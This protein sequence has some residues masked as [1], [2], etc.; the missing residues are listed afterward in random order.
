MQNSDPIS[1]FHDL[2]QR[3]TSVRV[4]EGSALRTKRKADKSLFVERSNNAL[5]ELRVALR[6]VPLGAQRSLMTPGNPTL[7]LSSQ[8][9]LLLT[10]QCLG[11]DFVRSDALPEDAALA[12]PGSVV[13]WVARCHEGRSK[14]T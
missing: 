6:L 9:G 14:L 5:A 8:D 7:A 10:I 1:R 2:T 4:V 3:V 13:A 12:V 11:D